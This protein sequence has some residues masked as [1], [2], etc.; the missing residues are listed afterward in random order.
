MIY[1]SLNCWVSPDSFIM[2]FE[3][4]LSLFITRSG[5]N[6]V[7]EAYPFPISLDNNN[8]DLRQIR[9]YEKQ[10][11]PRNQYGAPARAGGLPLRN[12]NIFELI[13]PF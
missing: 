6:A 1:Q 12:Y 11:Q 7:P 2:L 13:L 8:Q 9:R 4:K 10:Y 5:M 3:E